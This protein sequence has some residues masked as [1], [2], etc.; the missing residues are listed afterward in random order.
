MFSLFRYFCFVFFFFVVVVFRSR[1]Y[2]KFLRHRFGVYV[3]VYFGTNGQVVSPPTG[4]P[5]SPPKRTEGIKR[6]GRKFGSVWLAWDFHRFLAPFFPFVVVVLV[7]ESNTFWRERTKESVCCCWFRLS[8]IGRFFY[9][10]EWK[11]D[12]G[13]WCDVPTI[14][15]R[16]PLIVWWLML[17]SFLFLPPNDMAAALTTFSHLLRQRRDHTWLVSRRKSDQFSGLMR[18][19]KSPA[20]PSLISSAL[21][22]AN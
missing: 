3:D 2:R 18:K 13:T 20:V 21:P 22:T 9:Y 10:F 16:D 17:V 8:L 19:N 5:R 7:R 15:F 11:R 14:T 1:R 6:E 12:F 4:Q